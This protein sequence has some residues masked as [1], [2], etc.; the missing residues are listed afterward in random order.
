MAVGCNHIRKVAPVRASARG[1]RTHLSLLDL[2]YPVQGCD[3][4][5]GCWVEDFGVGAVLAFRHGRVCR[6]PHCCE[7][8]EKK[9]FSSF[10][11]P[12]Q[13]QPHSGLRRENVVT[14]MRLSDRIAIRTALRHYRKPTVG[15]HDHPMMVHSRISCTYLWG[16][17]CRS[18]CRTNMAHV[19]Q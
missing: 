15:S 13:G 6:W 17:C 1:A 16:E 8:P 3:P 19:R 18:R 5:Q 2:G 9:W 14:L 4:V 10:G 7:P 11:K 12:H